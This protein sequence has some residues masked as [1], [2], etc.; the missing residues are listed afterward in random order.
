MTVD[1]G[2]EPE[3]HRST[4]YGTLGHILGI[5]RKV[6]V[7]EAVLVDVLIFH[8]F[9]SGEVLPLTGGIKLVGAHTSAGGVHET[10]L[11]RLSLKFYNKT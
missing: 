4:S 10:D 9:G 2:V 5:E 6:H 1:L 3:V 7:H 8:L 11:S